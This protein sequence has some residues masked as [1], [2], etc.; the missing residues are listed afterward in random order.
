MHA[1]KR[2]FIYIR[3]LEYC[4]YYLDEGGDIDDILYDLPN[5]ISEAKDVIEK[6]RKDN[7]RNELLKI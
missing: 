6:K 4:S 1:E 2:D 5:R 7:T 3:I